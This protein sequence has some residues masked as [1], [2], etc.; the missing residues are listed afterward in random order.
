MTVT[1]L[2]PDLDLS[3]SIFPAAQD[4]GLTKHTALRFLRALARR[5]LAQ[6]V[7]RWLVQEE[8]RL[9]NERARR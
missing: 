1:D 7:A 4:E 8:Q 5:G 6:P 3:T 9:A 2:A